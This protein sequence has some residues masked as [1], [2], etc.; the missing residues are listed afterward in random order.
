[1][2]GITGNMIRITDRKWKNNSIRGLRIIK[3]RF[4]LEIT[5]LKWFNSRIIFSSDHLEGVFFLPSMICENDT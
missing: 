4:E 1:M 5:N 3:I 2:G